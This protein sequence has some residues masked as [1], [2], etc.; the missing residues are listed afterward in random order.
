MAT[1]IG[2]VSFEYKG[3]AV[4]LTRLELLTKLLPP[5]IA[6]TLFQQCEIVMTDSNTN[7]V[8]VRDGILRASGFVKRPVIEPGKISVTLGYGGAAKAYAAVQHENLD[9]KH[10]AKDNPGGQAGQPKY[11]ERPLLMHAG[12]IMQAVG[13][14]VWQAAQGVSGASGAS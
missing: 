5:K 12:E 2:N 4:V 11:L 8:P 9:Y 10:P 6:A 14:T 3:E 7:Y 13:A 1:V